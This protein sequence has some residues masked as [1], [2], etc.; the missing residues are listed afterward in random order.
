MTTKWRA[1]L[2]ALATVSVA[3]LAYY[4]RAPAAVADAVPDPAAATMYTMINGAEVPVSVGTVFAQVPKR[5]GRCI[6]TAPIGIGAQIPEGARSPA[7]T[8]RFN[9]ACEAVVTEISFPDEKI[10]LQTDGNR[11]PEVGE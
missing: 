6:I 2:A 7:I 4:D 1:G 3:S 5:D 8:W 10:E 11:T 9:D